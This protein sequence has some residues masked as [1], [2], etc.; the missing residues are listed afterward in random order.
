MLGD[1]FGVVG[2]AFLSPFGF[3][4]IEHNTDRDHFEKSVDGFALPELELAQQATVVGAQLQVGF[5]DEIVHQMLRGV[6]RVPTRGSAYDL[7]DERLKSANE[8]RPCGFVTGT[9]ARFD[10]VFRRE[11]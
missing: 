4:V 3:E 6:R 2:V 7:G 9:D 5:L 1:G 11:C 8:F 10:Q